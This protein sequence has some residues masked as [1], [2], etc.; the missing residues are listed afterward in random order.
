MRVNVSRICKQFGMTRQAYYK[1]RSRSVRLTGPLERTLLARVGQVRREQPRIGVRKLYHILRPP[2]GRDAFFDL[3]RRHS[4]LVKHRR[5]HA[6]TTYADRFSR[7]KNLIKS[8]PPMG[9]EQVVVSDLTYLRT[10][11]GYCYAALVTDLRS[12]KILGY[13][14]S[15]SLAPKGALEALEMALGQISDTRGLIHH[16]DRGFQYTCKAYAERLRRA[17]VRVSM[18]VQNHCYE[19]AVAERV[20]GILKEEF[21]LKERFSSIQYARLALRQAIHTYNH[22]RPHLTL[23]Y[24]TP[25]EEHAE[26]LQ[27]SKPK[28]VNFS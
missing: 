5:R 7:Y 22:K 17:G 20:N 27:N 9:A 8:N 13:S 18:T 25:A 3:L 19:N 15:E 24:K 16:S 4:L 23:N 26:L 6:V 12:R 21:L 14:L 1:K 28:S 10:T 11:T 2:I